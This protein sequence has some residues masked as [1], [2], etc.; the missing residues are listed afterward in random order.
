MNDRKS[1]IPL[2]LILILTVAVI[3]FLLEKFLPSGQG[4]SLLYNMSFWIAVVEGSIA[5]VAG[6]EISNG[7]WIKPFKRD[8]LSVYPLLPLFSLLFIIF[9]PR[10]GNY[11]WV[12]E[13]GFWLREDIFIGRSILLPLI[14]F[15]SAW[16][17]AKESLKEGK[18]KS[19]YAVIYILIFITS[20]TSVAFDW[21]MSLEYPWLSTLFGGLFF[22]ESFYAGLALG[23]ILIFFYHANYKE[24]FPDTFDVCHMDMAT[25]LFAFATFWGAQFYTQYLVI[26]YGNIPEEISMIYHRVATPGLRTASYGMVF[27]LFAVPFVSLLFRKLKMNYKF[28]LTI[29]FVVW[30]GVS[31]HRLVFIGPQMSIG[32]LTIIPEFILIGLLL[33]FVI[34]N[35][36]F[37]A[38][39]NT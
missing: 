36:E 38:L 32:P 20:Q 15:V 27:L 23:G 34:K 6:A 3:I 21:V 14:A 31:L 25:L 1:K 28:F 30:A 18:R 37:I 33:I 4:G 35:R 9:I 17:Y 2:L 24:K 13:T 19:F 29:S 39:K 11:P 8:M 22:I 7:K 26:W 10:I 5:V 12:H 16:K